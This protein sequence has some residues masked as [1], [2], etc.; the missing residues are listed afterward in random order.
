VEA[1]GIYHVMARGNNKQILFKDSEDYGKYV[2]C[3]KKKKVSIDIYSFVLMPNHV[4]FL[5]RTNGDKDLYRWMQSLHTAYG[6]YFNRRYQQTGH[7]FEGRYKSKAVQDDVYLIH[8]SR[9]IHMNPVAAGL[10]KSPEEYYW[11]SYPS[12]CHSESRFSFVET[13]FL[14]GIFWDQYGKTVEDFRKFTGDSM[15]D[16]IAAFVHRID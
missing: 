14:M 5:L 7:V 6:G 9:Y 2:K 13:S 4:H 3:L 8:L 16:Q 12:Y 15:R 11:S 10:I 1:N